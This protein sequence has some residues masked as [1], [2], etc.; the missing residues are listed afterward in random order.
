[1]FAQRF[2]CFVVAIFGLFYLFHYLFAIYGCDFRTFFSSFALLLFEKR[3][4]KEDELKEEKTRKRN[5][6]KRKEKRTFR[7]FPFL[8]V[9][10]FFVCT[11]YVRATYR[12]LL[13]RCT[14]V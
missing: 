3:H 4:E 9:L 11:L 7:F 5:F 8:Y 1:M 2:V 6:L 10:I 14:H 12:D 13:E